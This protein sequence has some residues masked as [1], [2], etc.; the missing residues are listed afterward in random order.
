MDQ[1]YLRAL[2]EFFCSHYT[3]YPKLGAI[4][5]Y[6]MPELLTIGKN[7]V[8]E[9]QNS[10]RMKLCYQSDCAALLQT[11]K[12][13]LVD[14]EFSFSFSYPSFPDRWRDLFRRHT[15]AKL[16]PAALARVKETP[17]GAGEKLSIEPEIWSK[18]CKGSLYPAKST[19]LALA[20]VC[21]L[22]AGDVSDLLAVTGFSLSNENVRDIVVEYLVTQKV[23]NPQMRDACLAE[24]RI[25][26]LPIRR[27]ESK[28][29]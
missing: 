13:G 4:E 2:D 23:F 14:T 21:R 3:D 20:L 15:F 22:S 27:E 26:T 6:R 29:A 9:R 25:D 1:D 12:R 8:L 28:N 18:I 7:G 19:V 11:F 5:G 10:E 24:Y 17:A 16:L